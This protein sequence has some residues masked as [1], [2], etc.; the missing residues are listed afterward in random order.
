MHELFKPSNQ[1]LIACALSL[2]ALFVSNLQS[3]VSHPA[4]RIEAKR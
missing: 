1:I 4:P 2:A 3:G